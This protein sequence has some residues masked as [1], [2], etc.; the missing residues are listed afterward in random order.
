MIMKKLLC[1]IFGHKWS[2][3]IKTSAFR[4]NDLCERCGTEEE[5]DHAF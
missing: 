5:H 1:K 4:T 3:P 2:Q